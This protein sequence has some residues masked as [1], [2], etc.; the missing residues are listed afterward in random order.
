MVFFAVLWKILAQIA[1]GWEHYDTK[2]AMA[3]SYFFKT[4]L[5]AICSRIVL[6]SFSVFYYFQN[7]S[8]CPF[9]QLG[10]MYAIGLAVDIAASLMSSIGVVW[11]HRFLVDRC[12]RK[13]RDTHNKYMPEFVLAEELGSLLDN[14]FVLMCGSTDLFLMPFGM[15]AVLLCEW[16]F[17]RIE[18]KY[19]IRPVV[20]TNNSFI[21]LLMVM[22]FIRVLVALLA[23]PI[24]VL[25]IFYGYATDCRS[26]QSKIAY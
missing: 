20:K 14:A 22:T 23:P 9:D 12:C 3:K 5:F 25:W 4:E 2:A 15:L 26:I 24:G 8:Q 10:Y 17:L 7:V 13:S 18:I 11:L 1:T 6:Y 16:F 21:K 19:F